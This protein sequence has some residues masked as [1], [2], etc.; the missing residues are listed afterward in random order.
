MVMILII[1]ICMDSKVHGMDFGDLLWCISMQLSWNS[2]SHVLCLV[3][4]QSR[5]HFYMIW[6]IKGKLLSFYTLYA[7]VKQV[8]L[9]LTHIVTDLSVGRRSWTPSPTT[10]T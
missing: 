2:S 4:D 7:I 5:L 9:H 8:L 10:P 6:K 3:S 1:K